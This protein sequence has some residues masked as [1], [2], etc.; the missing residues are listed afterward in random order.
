MYY[1]WGLGWRGGGLL[2][3]YGLMGMCHWMESHFHDSINYNGV[4]YSTEFLTELL[5]SGSKLLDFVEK[6]TGLWDLKME[7][8]VVKRS[9]Y[10]RN[11]CGAVDLILI[12]L[13]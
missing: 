11:N 3:I 4:A 7:R 13:A 2:D 8:F 12:L 1:P 6:N 5:E 9:F 10:L